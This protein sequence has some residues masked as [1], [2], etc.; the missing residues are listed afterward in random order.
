MPVLMRLG[1]ANMQRA[2]ISIEVR[3]THPSQLL[4]AST[5]LQGCL[6]ENSEIT[7]CRVD[8]PLRFTDVEITGTRNIDAAEEFDA[9][10]CVVRLQP[11]S[12]AMQGSAL[13]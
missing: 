7:L 6:D 2:G 13:L 5:G 3:Q 8:Q 4:I 10:P 12:L 1:L 11:S 9:L